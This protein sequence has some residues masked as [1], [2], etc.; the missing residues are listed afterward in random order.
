MKEGDHFKSKTMVKCTRMREIATSF[1]FF[2]GRTPDPLSKYVP[3]RSHKE[4]SF[5]IYLMALYKRM[6]SLVIKHFKLY[7]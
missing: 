3:K 5:K 7:I 6:C 2:W 4:I 1:T